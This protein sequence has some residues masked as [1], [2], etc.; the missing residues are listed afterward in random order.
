M[1]LEGGVGLLFKEGEVVLK[2]GGLKKGVT[3]T[4]LTYYDKPLVYGIF[5]K[6]I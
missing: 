3:E 5:C 2:R 6:S 1:P 4:P